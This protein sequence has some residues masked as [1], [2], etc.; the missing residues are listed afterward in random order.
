V[1]AV[2]WLVRLYPASLRDR[3]GDCLTDEVSVGGWRRLPNLL[4]GALD[5][6]VH[7]VVWPADSAAQRRRRAAVLAFVVGL[8][9]WLIGHLTVEESGLPASLTHSWTL[10]LCDLLVLLGLLLVV[11]LPRLS[12][13]GLA[14]FTGEV[15]RKL[16][17][18]VLI[19]GAVLARANL[20]TPM[21]TGTRTVLLVS[22]WVALVLGAIQVCGVVGGLGPDLTRPPHPVRLRLGIGALAA[23]YAISGAVVLWSTL[24]SGAA[25]VLA[26]LVGGTLFVLTVLC[27]WTL[28][29]LR[30]VALSD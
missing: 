23:S 5:M 17:V 10:N 1:S 9:G 11:P 26:A 16:A 29:D 14:R 30:A 7:P 2:S 3:W 15:V 28:H 6:W 27:G 8:G 18:P 19:G 24:S 21:S 4:L 20:A 25:G 13:A 12:I 22:W